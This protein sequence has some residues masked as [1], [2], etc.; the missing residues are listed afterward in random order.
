MDILFIGDVVGGPGRKALR[1]HLERN[2]ANYDIVVANGEN[3]AGGRGITHETARELFA[4]GVHVL[5]M[6][7]HVWDK[8]EAMTLLPMEGRIVRPANYPEGLPGKGLGF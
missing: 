2:S 1:N 8:K 6:G 7:N 5:T 4:A 3:A